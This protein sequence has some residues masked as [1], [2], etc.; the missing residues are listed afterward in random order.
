MYSLESDTKRFFHCDKERFPV[1][2]STFICTLFLVLLAHP[3]HKSTYHH[4]R[5]HD[6]YLHSCMHSVIDIYSDFSIDVI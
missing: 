3:V 6:F 5:I 2:F 1:K 4:K